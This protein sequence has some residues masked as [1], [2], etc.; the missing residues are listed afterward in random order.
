MN[1]PDRVFFARL[2]QVVDLNRDPGPGAMLA[3][4]GEAQLQNWYRARFGF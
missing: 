1:D 2:Q 3:A 4:G